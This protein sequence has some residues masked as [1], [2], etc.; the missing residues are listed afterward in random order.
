MLRNFYYSEH[1]LK[2]CQR[3]SLCTCVLYNNSADPE[4]QEVDSES[5]PDLANQEI[6]RAEEYESLARM[7]LDL[8][9]YIIFLFMI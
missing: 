4:G 1:Y 8:E 3:V 9:Q 6:V 2:I 7:C 5:N